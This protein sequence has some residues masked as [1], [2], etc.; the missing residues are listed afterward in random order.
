ML[1][2]P[3][4]G[5]RGLEWALKGASLHAPTLPPACQQAHGLRLQDGDAKTSTR[6]FGPARVRQKSARAFY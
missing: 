4:G 6:E 5:G 3:S 1:M 2:Q